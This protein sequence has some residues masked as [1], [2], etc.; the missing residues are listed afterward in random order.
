LPSFVGVINA[1]QPDVPSGG[2]VKQLSVSGTYNK[3]PA[4]ST[5]GNLDA[6][7]SYIRFR[8][9]RAHATGTN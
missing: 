3:V 2:S 8:A 5:N 9:R 7:S 4:S 6:Y 1:T